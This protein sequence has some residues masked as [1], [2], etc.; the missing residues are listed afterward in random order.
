[1]ALDND[2]DF[3]KDTFV[4]DY[5]E[6]KDDLREDTV[7]S[8][9]FSLKQFSLANDETIEN[10]IKNCLKQQRK[11]VEENG[12]IT[13]FNPNQPNSLVKKYIRN[14]EKFC[15]GKGNKNT[16]IMDKRDNIYV[17]LKHY[18][19][20]RPRRRKLE[21]DKK[22][23]NKL[24]K[25]DIRYILKDCNIVEQGLITFMLSTGLRRWDV[26]ELTIGDFMEATRKMEYH[27]FVEVDDF[28]DNAPDDMIG[29][30]DLIPHKES[31]N[32]IRCKTFNSGESSNLILQNLRRIKN[33]YIP[34]KKRKNNIEI[35]LEKSDALFGSRMKY[36]KESLTKEAMTN[37]IRAKNPR[38]KEWKIKQ[39]DANI[40]NKKISK[41]DREKEIEKIPT[42]NP[43]ALRKVFTNA[44]DTYGGL[45]LRANLVMEG[46][47]SPVSTDPNYVQ[48]QKEELFVGYKRILPHLTFLED[49]QVKILSNDESEKLNMEIDD[50]KKEK[51]NLEKQLEN[52]KQE[53]DAELDKVKKDMENK[54]KEVENRVETRLNGFD[55]PLGINKITSQ[56][57]QFN[58]L[59][60]IDRYLLNMVMHSTKGNESKLYIKLN[61]FN[62]EEQK[63]IKEIA[64][65]IAKHED[66]EDIEKIIKKA[67]FKFETDPTLR[68]KA[69]NHIKQ[70]NLNNEKQ[71]KLH[72]M[73]LSKMEDI[74]L[75]S[76]DESLEIWNK[77]KN[78]KVDW[79]KLLLEDITEEYVLGLIEDLM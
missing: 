16:T 42:I 26:S 32:D 8:Y 59:V 20:K 47:S 61:S 69:I 43:H 60:K 2:Y 56:D 40:N 13:E 58:F 48:K 57:K 6:G 45:S 25:E 24:S 62:D 79:D 64:Y 22:Q 54:L 63:A 71:T 77:I 4:I 75:W 7:K 10:I 76:E 18:E 37:A 14:F 12:E 3:E 27:N 5:F 46:H 11:R 73:L 78:N 31:K 49:V 68:S 34:N 17:F 21:D 38:F 41:E 72:D 50:L 74:G 33:E 23:W 1:M 39:I 44:V 15:E 35:K 9:K 70:S 30:W 66:I 53:K 52:L 29:F 51:N 65:D 28:I 55:V 67:V 19:V 36:Y